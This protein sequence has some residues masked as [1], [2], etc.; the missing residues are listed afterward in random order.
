MVSL[1]WVLT[2]PVLGL[3]AAGTVL[4]VSFLGDALVLHDAARS[5]ARAAAVTADDA[6]VAA[7]AR[8]AAP[9]LPGLRVTVTPTPRQVGHPVTVTARV[10]V[11]RGPVERELVARSVALVEPVVDHPQPT[12]FARHGWRA[13]PTGPT[14]RGVGPDV[15]PP[16]PTWTERGGP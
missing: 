2:L 13:G 12:G 14:G 6:R 1:E 4:V 3:V 16:G 9:E 7:V 5:A 8:D 10:V 15:V 11:R